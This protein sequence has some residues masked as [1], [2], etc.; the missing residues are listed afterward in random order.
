MNSS[1]SAIHMSSSAHPASVLP[2]LT[3]I[4]DCT[5]AK[6]VTSA[7]WNKTARALLHANFQMNP[8]EFCEIMIKIVP[9]GRPPIPAHFASCTGRALSKLEKRVVSMLALVGGLK[10]L[11]T[12]GS[13]WC[14]KKTVRGVCVRGEGREAQ[15]KKRKIFVLS[16]CDGCLNKGYI[17]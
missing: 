4:K 1:L 11:W 10:D 13:H 6:A 2:S 14:G 5:R 3:P 8:G 7:A 15:R 17:Y 12:V 9:A 16:S